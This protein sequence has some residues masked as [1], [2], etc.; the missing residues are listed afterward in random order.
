ML[1]HNHHCGHYIMLGLCRI[2][3]EAE[4]ADWMMNNEWCKIS[5]QNFV[6]GGVWRLRETEKNVCVCVSENTYTR[7]MYMH[8]CR[9]ARVQTYV[10]GP[11]HLTCFVFIIDNRSTRA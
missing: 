10:Q 3:V 2:C 5:R 1:R 4:M 8:V 9:P 7:Y 6:G 11:I